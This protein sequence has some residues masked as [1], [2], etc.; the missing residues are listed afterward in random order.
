LIFERYKSE[1]LAHYSYLIADQGQAAVIDPRWDIDVYLRDAA[2]DQAYIGC[3]FETHRNE[4]Y[5]IGSCEIES[6]TWMLSPKISL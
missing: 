3:V 6:R 4:D 5:L 2:Q 1:G